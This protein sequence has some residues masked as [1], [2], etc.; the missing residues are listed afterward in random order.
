MKKIRIQTLEDLLA[1]DYDEIDKV[2][3]DIKD[4]KKYYD[5]T[6]ERSKKYNEIEIYNWTLDYDYWVEPWKHSYEI[7]FSKRPKLDENEEEE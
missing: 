2:V 6:F 1:L 7:S 3:E 5:E 4:A